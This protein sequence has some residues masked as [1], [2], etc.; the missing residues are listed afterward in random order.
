MYYLN[1][2]TGVEIQLELDIDESGNAAVLNELFTFKSIC[3]GDST[4]VEKICGIHTDTNGGG[5]Y[6]NFP[7][8]HYKCRFTNTRTKETINYDF[9]LD[10]RFWSLE[11]N[12]VEFKTLFK[13]FNIKLDDDNDPESDMPDI[14]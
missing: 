6:L 8:L 2:D 14:F 11:K 1:Y 5:S 12:P 13:W 9:N 4:G 7:D 10:N 3:I